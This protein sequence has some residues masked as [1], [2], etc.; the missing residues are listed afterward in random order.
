MKTILIAF[1][2]MALVLIVIAGAF[3]GYAIYGV[4]VPAFG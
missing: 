2:G 1:G 4:R 3:F